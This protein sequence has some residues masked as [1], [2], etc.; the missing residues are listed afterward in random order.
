M[1]SK[2]KWATQFFS[3]FFKVNMYL[4]CH[5][6]VKTAYLNA[7]FNVCLTRD[8]IS[9]Y[10]TF[11]LRTAYCV[12]KRHFL[13]T[14]YRYFAYCVRAT[15]NTAYEKKENGDGVHR[16]LYPAKHV[17]QSFIVQHVDQICVLTCYRTV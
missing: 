10:R 2:C 1:H 3:F 7:L 12:L 11:A 5:F 13:S 4:A 9:A 15:R 6:I 14:F 17:D 16:G 8:S